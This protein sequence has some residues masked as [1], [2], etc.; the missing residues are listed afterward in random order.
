M[1]AK[2]VLK[3]ISVPAA[4]EIA[5][6]D[7]STRSIP[8]ETVSAPAPAPVPAPASAAEEK[9]GR[10]KREKKGKDT[11][12][13]QVIAVV[14]PYGIEGSFTTEPRK[15]LICHLP[16]E[17]KEVKFTD[18]HLK[19][20][21]TPPISEP[22]PY[23]EKEDYFG[24]LSKGPED[25]AIHEHVEAYSDTW[26]MEEVK[27]D[28]SQQAST[29]TPVAAVASTPAAAPVWKSLGENFKRCD[30]FPCYKKGAAFVLPEKTEMSCFW[31]VQTFSNAPCFIPMRE[32]K[33]AFHIYGNFCSP[34]CGLAHLLKEA[35][36]PHVRWERMALL[37][38]L[39]MPKAGGRLYP[40]PPRESLACFGGPYS[41]DEYRS[42]IAENKLRIDIQMPPMVSILGSL[43]T[44]PIDFYDSSLQNTFTQGLLGIS[45]RFA[46]P[47]DGSLRLRR[48]KPLKDHESTL[49]ACIQISFRSSK[50]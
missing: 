31:C 8:Q 29:P 4:A 16:F 9:K 32:E 45:E 30:L 35:L 7:S 24:I 6:A 10:A 15:P 25:S 17:S 22:Q 28:V 41:H 38:R 5:V 23:A 49:D 13:I 47:S 11:K 19:Y 36:D 18:Q 37:H 14:T 1:P 50:A 26:I 43:D 33:G 42:I 44:K 27:K 48:S 40:S 39:Y 21:P 3:T 34:Q 46:K 2:K 20:D 12:K